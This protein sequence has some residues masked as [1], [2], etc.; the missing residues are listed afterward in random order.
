MN[1]NHLFLDIITISLLLFVI[2]VLMRASYSDKNSETSNFI[3]SL[4]YL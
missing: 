3:I 1:N 4:Y 2:K